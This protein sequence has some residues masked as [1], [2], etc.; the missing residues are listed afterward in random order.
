VVSRAVAAPL[1]AAAAA[2][3]VAAPASAYCPSYTLSSS[4]NSNQCGVEAANGTNPAPAAWAPIF[5]LVGQGPGAWGTMGP[6][7][8]PIPQGCA[9]P[10]PAATV[11]AVFPCELL[12]AIAMQ[13]SAWRQFCVPD[14]PADQAH[15]PERTIIAVD[16]GYGVGQVTSGMHIGETPSFDRA[17][18]AADPTYNLATGALILA[19]KWRTT[20]CVGDRQPRTV[21]H[22]YTAS[23]A[24][25]GLAFVNNPNNP[26]YSSTRGVCDPN[27]DCG[28]RPYQER[29]WGWMEHPP[30][31]Q[32]WNAIAPAYP[33]LA[34]L[35]ATGA[36]VPALP[37][38]RCASPTSCASTRPT[39]PSAC[40][41]DATGAPDAGT[42]GGS[43]GGCGCELGRDAPNARLGLALLALLALAAALRY[44]KRA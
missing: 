17:R 6:P 11:A 20:A 34:D 19:D 22:W 39:H 32:Y 7:I 38:P 4:A 12:E 1:A 24:Y 10:S 13:E 28:A 43:Q 8:D 42:G 18:V 29:V 21:E 36:T 27:L 35:P 15:P 30:T 41:G 40:L 2:L 23:W 3:A 9:Q 14:Q 33:A 16:C 5:A 25:N 31:G 26:N 37:E 44:N